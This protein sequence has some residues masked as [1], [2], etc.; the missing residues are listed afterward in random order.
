M[1][2]HSKDQLFRLIKSLSKAEKR[3]FR[4]YANRT[5]SSQE[6]K[7][8]QLFDALDKI[9][10]YDDDLLIDRLEGINRS[11]LPH[12]K[13]HLFKQLLTSL[14][15]INIQ[16]NIDIQ[17]REQLDFARILY[18]KGLYMESLRILERNK[19]TA[20]G[21]H[22]DILHLEILE[23]Q[24]LIEARHIT[25]SRQEGRKMDQLLVD[26]THRSEVTLASSELSNL[27]IQIQGH[28]IDQGHAKNPEEQK[29]VENLW[30]EMQPLPR[31]LETVGTF[32]EKINRF[33]SRMWYNYILLHFGTA[34]EN[35]SEWVGLFRLNPQMKEKDPDLY[36][37]GLYYLLV[38]QFLNDDNQYYAR[39]LKEFELFVEEMK[40]QFTPV[41]KHIAFQY[42]ALS[43]LN[44]YLLSKSF[45][46]GYCRVPEI[47]AEL[48]HHED[49]LDEHRLM[50]FQ[51]KFA[52][53]AFAAGHYAEALDKLDG[54]LDNR[55]FLREDLHYNSHLLELLCRFQLRQF[56]LLDYR[57][58]ALQRLLS[59]GRD[60]S[61]S[62][63]KA[64]TLLRQLTSKP[65][66]ERPRI[67]EKALSELNS[68][69]EDPYENKALKY[70]D[71]ISWIESLRQNTTIASFWQQNKNLSRAKEAVVLAP[72]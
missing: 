9:A 47:S 19:E 22:Q 42:L 69:K 40:E 14:R 57:I 50:L 60:V 62:L 28:Y 41:S 3:H 56:A 20:E 34:K 61:Q 15:L 29:Q 31:R 67:L 64:L 4:L 21:H 5:M 68:L 8:L 38:F 44:G 49:L 25:R 58:T 13:R 71:L 16:N 51:Y 48:A 63:K 43:Q 12:L 35:A 46:E 55:S 33:Q 23:F 26:S 27:N 39:Y 6:R 36:M 10:E 30:E 65:A 37:R 11:N 32:F 17:I 2:N 72:E 66:S 45:Q 24:K 59:K 54:I 70:L 53:L 7:F 52:C 1:S 18:S